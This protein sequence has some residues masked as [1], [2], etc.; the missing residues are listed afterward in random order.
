MTYIVTGAT[1]FIGKALVDYLLMSN[2]EVYAVSRSEERVRLLWPECCKL[3]AIG[4][5]MSDYK[6]LPKLVAQADVFVH[7]A[8]EGTGHGGRDDVEVQQQNIECTRLAMLAAHRMG[9]KLFVMAGSQA[10]Y[11]STKEPQNEAMTCQPVSEYGKAKLR[12]REMGFDLAEQLGMKYMHLRIFSLYGENDHAWTLVMS[13]VD[14]ML[15]NEPIDL[16]PC[17][18]NWNF[19]YV[20]DAARQIKQLCKHVIQEDGFVHEVYNIASNDTRPLRDFV[21]RMK[22]LTSTKSDLHYGAVIPTHVVSLQ[23]KMSK[24]ISVVGK[25]SEYDFDTVIQRIMNK[26]NDKT[27]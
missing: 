17:T 2:H 7:L 24:T 22:E 9:C 21:E 16:S 25:L 11:G 8:W 1:G 5:E 13:C 14:K 23:P 18:Q 3:H 15:R 20:K 27:I 12:V 10:E 6:D 26:H 19:L 4:C